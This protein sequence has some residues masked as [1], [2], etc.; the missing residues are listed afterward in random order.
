MSFHEINNVITILHLDYQEKE[1]IH[2]GCI[3]AEKQGEPKFFLGCK[4]DVDDFRRADGTVRY[5]ELQNYEHHS[6]KNKFKTF[7]LSEN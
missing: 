3:P 7:S 6:N 4:K 5:F 1:Y 2:R